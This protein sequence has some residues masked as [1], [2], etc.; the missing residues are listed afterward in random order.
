MA[1]PTIINSRYEIRGVVGRGGM[2]LVYK[3]FDRVVGRD[4]AV[5]TLVDIQGRAALDA[6]YKEW[7]LL[8]NLHHPNI[9]EIFDIG[10]FEEDGVVKPF[11][12]MPLLPGMPLDQLVRTPGQ[13]ITAER[14]GE[15]LSQVCRGLQ[16]IHDSGLVHR[17]IK[18]S[19]IFVMDFNSVKLIDFGVAHLM[20][21]NTLTELK[22]TVAYMAPEQIQSK[23]CSPA[24]DIFSLGVVAYEVL[25]G[26]RPF[27]GQ[28]MEEVFEAILHHSPQ[29]IFELNP[30]IS[31]MVSRVVHKALAKQPRHRY[32]N[33]IE[34][35]EMYQRALRGEAIP[36]FDPA[37]IQ[38]RIERAVRAFEQGNPQMA[39]DIL[40]DLD[41]SGHIDPA[42]VPL[43]ARVDEALRRQNI[44]DLLDR[45]KLA[46]E[47]EEFALAAQNIEAV[48]KMEPE[49]AEALKLSE[50]VRAEVLRR[51]LDEALRNGE[52]ALRDGS[53]GRARQLLKGVLESRP[54]EPRAQQLLAEIEAAEQAYRAALQEKESLYKAAREAWQNS[55]FSAAAIML[56]R[57]VELETKAPDSKS[58]DSG[59]NYSSFLS[60]VEHARIVVSEVHAK[61]LQHIA[62]GHF[63]QAAELCRKCAEKYPGHPVPQGLRLITEAA[64][65]RALF[66]HLAQLIQM[67]DTRNDC[68]DTLEALENANAEFPAMPAFDRWLNAVR[69]QLA[70][71][72]AVEA[73]ARAHEEAKRFRQALDEWQM[74]AL[75]DPQRPGLDAEIDRVARLAGAAVE[76]PPVVERPKALAMA[77]AVGPQDQTLAFDALA[78]AEAT[79]AAKPSGAPGVAPEGTAPPKPSREKP[80]A[81]GFAG[82]IVAV[83]EHA[84]RFTTNPMFRRTF[85]V[86]RWN[87][88]LASL[89]AGIGFLVLA[90]VAAVF[91]L[92]DGRNR[93]PVPGPQSVAVSIRSATPGATIRVGNQ[94]THGEFSAELQPGDYPLEVR[95]AGYEA[96]RDKI[97]VPASGLTMTVP[98]L[99]PLATSL[100]ISADLQRARVRVDGQPESPMQDGDFQADD[101][102]AGDHRVVITDGHSQA[103]VA[104][105]TAIAT[106]PQIKP[107]VG[108]KELVA[109]VA[110]ALGPTVTIR[111]SV[112]PT[113]VTVDGREA[114]RNEAGAFQAG[115]LPEGEHEIAV[116][117]GKDERKFA[118][119]TGD[120]PEI[121]VALYSD[122]DVGSIVVTTGLPDFRVFIDGVQV[123][124]NIRD[125]SMSI[126]GLPVKSYKVRVVADGYQPSSEPVLEVKKGGLVKQVFTLTAIP[127][128][129][130]LV[131]KGTPPRTQV[132]IDNTAVGTTDAE[133]SLT[134]DKVS[135]GEHTV[136]LRNPPQYKP[137]QFRRAFDGRE[138]IT[139]SGAEARL[140]RN[141]ATIVLTATP[142]GVHFETRCGQG[143]AQR[144]PAPVTVTCGESQFS[145]R[146]T[147][148][149]YR[150][151]TET[152]T[153]SPGETYRKPVEL[154]KVIVAVRKN[155][156]SMTDLPKRGWTLEEGWY[157]AGNDAVLPCDDMIG[158]YQF[159]VRLPRGFAARSVSWTVQSGSARQ[160]FVLE[161][162]S[163]SFRG[164]Q[165]QDI[166]KYDEDGH[167][168]FRLINEGNRIIHE[169][170]AGNSWERLSTNEGDFRKSR[171]IFSKDARIAAFVFNEH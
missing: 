67:A 74:L 161:K 132:L 75:I 10:E 34:F 150:D 26:V 98:E 118:V 73:K 39:M 2:G 166:S 113:K 11:F 110:T 137:A 104:F 165:K 84:V 157:A 23:G 146:A 90:A 8:A 111:S 106:A 147:L 44:R 131:V 91:M 32:S 66:V 171:V 61:C 52:A 95:L 49:N 37:R 128:F 159:A 117:A 136:E 108:A 164:G 24:S 80:R 125:G 97:V 68:A 50:A 156:C 87:L 38:P 85:R 25:C 17:D 134:V 45:T 46:L 77:V 19:N 58:P 126:G 149:G 99:R 62:E 107:P 141:A 93:P 92:R 31:Q 109:L 148:E 142:E 69:E 130:T 129:A 170:K 124:R 135:P 115:E 127:Q 65:Q 121:R 56:K 86:G 116:L 83:R 81:G 120:R 63:Q 168:S 54:E 169:V 27:H 100:H 112:E 16:A 155:S 20:G 163:F 154:T 5:K 119:H 94:T 1:M 152:I 144:R 42:L 51:E 14:F 101:L 122:R 60:L 105:S 96:V 48:L 71:S 22:G 55:E 41:A 15:I 76:Y 35:A 7:R 29:P 6:F 138:S 33:A 143:P 82:R 103:T 114:A 158:T 43:R 140:E 88:R 57:V 28:H 79:G 89:A 21:G 153:L 151:V 64:E 167:I 72:Q 9:I 162:K 47:E 30:T 160:Q 78:K 133:G 36:I 13:K 4:V 145:Y 102:A 40:N 139:I 18:P 53:Y 123:T 70:L 12:V 59:T 3:A